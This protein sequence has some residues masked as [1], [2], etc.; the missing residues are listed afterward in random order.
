MNE[1]IYALIMAG[2]K[3]T[4][5]KMNIEKPLLRINKITILERIINA[6]NESKILKGM[7]FAVSP[8]TPKTRKFISKNKYDFIETPGEE[9]H[10]DLKFAIKELNL[11]KTLVLSCDL[12]FLTDRI[13]D[14]VL[15]KYLE[16]GKPA[17]AIAAPL[18]L[19][20]DIEIKPSFITVFEQRKIAILGLNCIDG[21]LIDNGLME[22]SI[23]IIDDLKFL[24]NINTL[25]ELKFARKYY[26]FFE[27]SLKCP[28]CSYSIDFQNFK[29][30]IEQKIG[31]CTHCNHKISED[32]FL[33]MVK[34]KPN[35]KIN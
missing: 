8:H 6:L 30:I 14:D 18:E 19:F 7:I 21:N 2:G 27:K 20:K 31:R 11:K 29:M 34:S 13:I 12:P 32:F 25:N 22:E 33:N 23:Y 5:L 15:K 4:R 24:I 9:Y 35:L 3:G 1:D 26:L 16:L 28:N 17:L 10:P